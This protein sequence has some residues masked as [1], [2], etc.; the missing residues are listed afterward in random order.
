MIPEIT[1]EAETANIRAKAPHVVL[2]GA[3]R[4]RLSCTLRCPRG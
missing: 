1:V 4:A 2:L 3:E